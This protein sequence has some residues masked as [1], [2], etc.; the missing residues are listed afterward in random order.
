MDSQTD[1]EVNQEL[2]DAWGRFI[3]GYATSY[4]QNTIQT[5]LKQLTTTI[6]DNCPYC[7]NKY[8]VT[9]TPD[10]FAQLVRVG[11]IKFDCPFC[12][13]FLRPKIRLTLG[14][15]FW[16]IMNGDTTPE[17]VFIGKPIKEKT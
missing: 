1:Y 11:W 8:K 7:R 16:K 9:L 15:L 10:D 2:P 14:Q 12:K 4:I 13:G 5:Q 3:R 6:E 17:R